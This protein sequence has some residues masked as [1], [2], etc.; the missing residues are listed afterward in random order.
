MLKR[1]YCEHDQYISPSIARI[2]HIYACQET[3]I[4][5]GQCRSIKREA[6]N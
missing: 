4:S 1:L 3:D 5:F 6:E 2:V